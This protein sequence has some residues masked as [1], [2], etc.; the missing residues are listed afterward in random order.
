[1]GLSVNYFASLGSEYHFPKIGCSKSS[2]PKRN[3]FQCNLPKTIF[4]VL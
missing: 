2:F 1:M 4:C 3:G